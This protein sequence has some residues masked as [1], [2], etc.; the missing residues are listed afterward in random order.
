[1]FK[2]WPVNNHFE[3]LWDWTTL[4]LKKTLIKNSN[5]NSNYLDVGTGPF[6]V[7]AVYSEKKQLFKTITAIDYIPEFIENAK[8][9]DSADIAFKNSNLFDQVQSRYNVITFNSPYIIKK[10]GEMLGN[11]N[12]N[13]AE[14]R[15]SGGLDGTETINRFLLQAYNH[16]EKNGVILLGI[17]TFHLPD[18][19][20]TELINST[21]Y[22]IKNKYTNK[23]TKG[24][25]YEL[26]IK[27]K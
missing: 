4:V 13:L 19:I 21:N 27:E 11:F 18:Q 2:Y 22:I 8:K 24:L 7:L 12:S 5:I 15:W 3:N 10:K 16:L 1:M 6:A 20:C 23:F 9:Q 25:V 14:K 26:I 17:N